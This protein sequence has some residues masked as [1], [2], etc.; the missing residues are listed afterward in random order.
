LLQFAPIQGEIR[1]LL[2]RARVICASRLKEVRHFG[3][4]LRTSRHLPVIEAL[5]ICNALVNSRPIA[6]KS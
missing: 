1:D 4:N 6:Q 5:T 3:N 2:L